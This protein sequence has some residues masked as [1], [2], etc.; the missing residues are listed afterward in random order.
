MV[1]SRALIRSRG[2]LQSNFCV[3]NLRA[4]Q[5]GIELYSQDYDQTYPQAARWMD[6]VAPY[7]KNRRELYCPV[8]HAANPKGIGYAFN[9]KLSGANAAKI[10]SPLTTAVVYDSADVDRNAADS[11][12]TLPTPARHVFPD[13]NSAAKGATHYNIVLYADGKVRFL[14]ADGVTRDAPDTNVRRNLFGTRPKA[15]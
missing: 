6:D 7:I 3:T 11:F 14:S 10:E 4:A 12:S 15:K 13:R 5:R 2:L 8:V 1:A 9:Q